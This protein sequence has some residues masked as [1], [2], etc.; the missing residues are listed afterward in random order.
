M[1]S[2]VVGDS[3]TVLLLSLQFL[4]KLRIA[5]VL[6]HINGLV[7]HSPQEGLELR[8][9]RMFT[10]TQRPKGYIPVGYSVKIHILKH[11]RLVGLQS[12]GRNIVPS[13]RL[14]SKDPFILRVLLRN[15]RTEPIIRTGRVGH[16]GRTR[17]S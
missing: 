7:L 4:K 13:G 9:R 14:N 11:I 10:T 17:G 16:W 5:G 6:D 3:V 8:K 15:R 2:P 1:T 12:A